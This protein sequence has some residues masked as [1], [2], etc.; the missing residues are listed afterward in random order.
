MCTGSVKNSLECPHYNRHYFGI[1]IIVSQNVPYLRLRTL[2]SPYFG[3]PGASPL[4]LV[5][6]STSGENRIFPTDTLPGRPPA[7]SRIS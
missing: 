5:V 4:R 7:S 3:E 2:R 6:V 1:M